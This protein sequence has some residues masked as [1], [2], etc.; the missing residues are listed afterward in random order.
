MNHVIETSS[1][2]ANKLKNTHDD[3][4]KYDIDVALDEVENNE[5]T[6]KLK[7]K[8]ML[9]SN[10]VNAKLTIEGLVTLHGD[11]SDVLK[12]LTPD[13][14]NTPRIVNVVYQEIFPLIYII[15]KDMQIPC[16]AY[17]MAQISSSASH[18]I[19]EELVKE[20]PRKID[21]VEKTGVEQA[22]LPPET[23]DKLVIQEATVSSI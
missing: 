2:V 12:Q 18:I 16:P 11:E 21:T 20:P 19:Q 4:I 22:E 14:N 23:V 9:L 17:K 3:F 8:I 6:M 1:L 15:C 5:S 7:Y 10:P 13:Q